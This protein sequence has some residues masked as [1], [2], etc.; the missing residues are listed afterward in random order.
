MGKL[1]VFFLSIHTH[2]EESRFFSQ[3]YIFSLPDQTDQTLNASQSAHPE[4]GRIIK[5]LHNKQRCS[6]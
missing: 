3:I 6:H 4:W 2:A 1:I 5:E